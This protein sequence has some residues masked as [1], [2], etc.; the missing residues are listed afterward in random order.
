MLN[1]LDLKI[2]EGFICKKP[3]GQLTKA[4]NH[5]LRPSVW[6]PLDEGFQFSISNLAV[7]LACFQEEVLFMGKKKPLF[8][9]L[10]IGGNSWFLSSPAYTIYKNGLVL[11]D[12]SNPK[13]RRQVE[14]YKCSE[15]AFSG[16]I[17]E[18]GHKYALLKQ[19]GVI[20]GRG[21][22]VTCK[23]SLGMPFCLN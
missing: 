23:E 6:M 13:T 17:S 20:T 3:I 8:L 14:N 1:A 10:V 2:L 16:F 22:S 21:Q 18:P 19:I 5:R 9:L 15:G 11:A 4:F 12:I 7:V